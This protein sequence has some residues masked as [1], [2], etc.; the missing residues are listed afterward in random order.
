MSSS[1]CDAI[2][3]H[4]L[5]RFQCFQN[6]ASELGS[7]ARRKQICNLF[8]C[9]RREVL[10]QT[11]EAHEARE[12]MLG[13]SFYYSFP[14]AFLLWEV[15]VNWEF[16]SHTRETL[17]SWEMRHVECAWN[18]RK[19]ISSSLLMIIWYDLVMEMDIVHMAVDGFFIEL[20]IKCAFPSP[21]PHSARLASDVSSTHHISFHF[22]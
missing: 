1:S 16:V 6:R 20:D 22:R 8:W 10:K 5:S 12:D 21:P 15:N 13:A 2:I 11:R 3:V 17:K 18:H 9:E 14:L 7:G 19:I 4:N